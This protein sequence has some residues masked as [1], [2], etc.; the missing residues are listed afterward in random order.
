MIELTRTNGQ[1]I[2]V[3]C[4]L[5]ESIESNGETIVLLTTGN[6]LVVRDR[7]DEIERKVVAFRRKILAPPESG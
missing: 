7:L 5:I 4:D 6:A 1:P 3:N 2:L